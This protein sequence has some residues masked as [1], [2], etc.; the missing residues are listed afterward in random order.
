MAHVSA[1]ETGDVI[2]R[3]ENRQ[4][5]VVYVLRTVP[6]SDQ[7]TVDDRNA[8][9]TQAIAV[10][11]QQRVRAWLTEDDRVTLLHDAREPAPKNHPLPTR[12]LRFEE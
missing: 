10:A 9:I 7:Y 1:P 6:G 4:G 12:H 2:A 8:A 5:T 3:P 11:Q